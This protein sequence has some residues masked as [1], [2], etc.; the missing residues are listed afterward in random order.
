MNIDDCINEFFDMP[1]EERLKVVVALSKI[2]YEHMHSISTF[3]ALIHNKLHFKEEDYPVLYA[4][5]LFEVHNKLQIND[6]NI[7]HIVIDRI[8]TSCKECPFLQWDEEVNE[9][10]C[11]KKDRE[12]DD[13]SFIPDWCPFLV[14]ESE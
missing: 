4:S 1:Y 7:A 11:S 10:Y 2:L 13:V 12:I 8:T 6:K 3:S 14:E 5:G 9:Y